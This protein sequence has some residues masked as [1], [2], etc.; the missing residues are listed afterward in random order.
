M[1]TV[2]VVATKYFFSRLYGYK[3]RDLIHKNMKIHTPQLL[4]FIRHGETPRNVVQS[5]SPIH[6]RDHESKKGV[7]GIPDHC[8]PLTPRGIAQARRVGKELKNRFGAF[9]TAYHS[10]Y[11]RTEKTLAGIL[12]AYTAEERARLAIKRSIRLRERESGYSFDMT[13][14]EAEQHFPWMADYWK[15]IGPLFAR[16]S[17]GESLAQVIE[18][19]EPFLEKMFREE[20]G[21]RVCVVMHGRVLAAIRFLLENWTYEE[22]EAFLNHRSP[23]NCGV[24]VYRPDS[25]NGI[26][27]LSEYNTVYEPDTA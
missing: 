26:L 17:G 13:K 14:D 9:D 19:V 12:E 22:A 25:K 6:F 3:R 24:T 11:V 1:H 20:E 21:K 23:K 7:A 16:P 10:G 8:I 15:T 27:A 18:R 2:G 5:H 4:V